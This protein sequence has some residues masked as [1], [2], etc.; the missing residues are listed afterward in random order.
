MNNRTIFIFLLSLALSG[1]FTGSDSSDAVTKDDT[2]TTTENPAAESGD[3]EAGE[4]AS[5]ANNDDLVFGTLSNITAESIKIQVK[6]FWRHQ[7]TTFNG[8][9]ENDS[10]FDWLDS[11]FVEH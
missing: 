2:D 4:D 3:S 8:A 10:D 1:C 6:V 5:P 7:N 11:K 9:T